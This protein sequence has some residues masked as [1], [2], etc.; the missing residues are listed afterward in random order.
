MEFLNKGQH[1][2]IIKHQDE[3]DVLLLCHVF[4]P[5][6]RTCGALPCNHRNPKKKLMLRP[7]AKKIATRYHTSLSNMLDVS[8]IRN[9][10]LQKCAIMSLL[11]W[12]CQSNGEGSGEWVN[13]CILTKSDWDRWTRT[14]VHNRRNV[15]RW[16]VWFDH[17]EYSRYLWQWRDRRGRTTACCAAVVVGPTQ[18]Q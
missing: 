8:I 1:A 14:H 18:G 2:N 4:T 17:I 13:T 11:I 5:S 6:H 10:R 7:I 9:R 15:C 16:R 12:Y 3:E